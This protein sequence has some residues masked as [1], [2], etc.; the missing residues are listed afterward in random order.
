MI[1]KD[2]LYERIETLAKIG[3]TEDG[4]VTRLALTKED[5]EA[6]ELVSSWMKE[7][8][9]QVRRDSAGNLIGRKEG[10]EPGAKTIV[11]GS[12][13][14]SVGNG[15]KLDGTIGVIGGIEVVQHIT[16]EGIEIKSP[17]EVIAFCEEEGS[18]FQSGGIF[19]SRAM[20]GK[21]TRK[22]L[23]V[24]D[25]KGISRRDALIHFGLDPEGIFNEVIRKKDEIG[26]Y[27][28]MHIEQGP[29]LEAAEIPVGIVTAITGLSLTEIT[30]EGTPNHV[31]GTPMGMRNDAL[32][33]ASEFAI[34]TEEICE[35]FGSPAVGTVASMNVYPN[36][37][38]I[39]PG[40][41]I[42]TVDVR[43]VDIERRETI[44]EKL[45]NRALEISEKRG[46]NVDFNLKLK[47][48]P[49][50]CNEKVM[51]LMKSKAKEAGI[52]CQEIVSGGGHDAQLMAELAD[53]G[54]IFVRSTGGSH[55]PKES[56]KIDDI[57]LG[58]K[59]LSEVAIHYLIKMP[60]DSTGQSII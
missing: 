52:I 58:T 25:S 41:V 45:R 57:T 5:R 47:A 13:I 1:N 2:R 14:D 8:G 22:D 10:K 40:K 19:G 48:N 37:V 44:L 24:R 16:E 39:V 4:G 21:I 3:A 55:N 33:G 20:T 27:L 30:F 18:R 59:L 46:L 54:M 56:A 29:I 38:N 36:Q 17:V 11:M 26:L 7:A 51:E 50:P 49:A 34:A 28:E 32:L 6:Q 9:M 35:E 23:E 31:G 42:L 60:V 43:D 53:M 12:H 15:G